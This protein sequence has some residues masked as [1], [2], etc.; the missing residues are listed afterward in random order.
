MLLLACAPGC[1]WLTHGET[2]VA[3]TAD[4]VSRP[5]TSPSSSAPT[6]VAANLWADDQWVR[7]VAPPGKAAHHAPAYHWRNPSLELLS[8]QFGERQP[9]L[10]AS[11]LEGGVQGANAAIL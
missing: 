11:L 10:E 2:P 9:R 5:S 4:A 7:T 6:P 3:S 1:F 8:A